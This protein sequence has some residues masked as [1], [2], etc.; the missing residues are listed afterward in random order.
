MYFT[1]LGL[2]S[3]ISLK[4]QRFD[5][6]GFPS[7]RFSGAAASSVELLTPQKQIIIVF[8]FLFEINTSFGVSDGRVNLCNS[9]LIKNKRRVSLQQIMIYSSAAIMFRQGY[10]FVICL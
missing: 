3:A 6:M 1:F 10:T 2:A 8:R 9:G 4:K 5:K 7:S